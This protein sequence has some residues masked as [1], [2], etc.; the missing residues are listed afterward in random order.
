[1][2]DDHI[3]IIINNNN[4]T[5]NSMIIQQIMNRIIR[6][7]VTIPATTT[8]IIILQIQIMD[9]IIEDGN[10]RVCFSFFLLYFDQY[11]RCFSFFFYEI[12]GKNQMHLDLH[13]LHLKYEK[14]QLNLIQSQ[15]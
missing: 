14:F 11:E 10:V 6:A 4:N 8:T 5:L 9:T 2:N 7:I 12:K 13:Q 15:N 3:I 1:M